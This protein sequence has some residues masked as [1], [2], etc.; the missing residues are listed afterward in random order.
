MMQ[1]SWKILIKGPSHGE[2]TAAS[3]EVNEDTI[4]VAEESALTPEVPWQDIKVD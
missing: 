1:N 2:N 3:L 4:Y